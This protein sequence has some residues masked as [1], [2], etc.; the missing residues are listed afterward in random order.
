MKSKQAVAVGSMYRNRRQAAEIG[1]AGAECDL[2]GPSSA[3]PPQG[4]RR[5]KSILRCLFN[6]IYCLCMAYLY[7][8]STSH[9]YQLSTIAAAGL[10]FLQSFYQPPVYTVTSYQLPSS[11]CV[12]FLPIF[13]S[14]YMNYFRLFRLFVNGTSNNICMWCSAPNNNLPFF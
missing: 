11:Y 6:P 9:N 12:A 7:C 1:V 3:A 10:S 13:G 14:S 4:R 8:R 5:R 2:R